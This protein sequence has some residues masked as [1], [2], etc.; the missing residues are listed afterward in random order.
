MIRLWRRG[1]P[2]VTISVPAVERCQQRR[3]VPCHCNAQPEHGTATMLSADFVGE[4][5]H[6]VLLCPKL[7]ANEGSRCRLMFCDNWSGRMLWYAT[8][9]EEK[10]LRAKLPSCHPS[11]CHSWTHRSPVESLSVASRT[12]TPL[13]PEEEHYKGKSVAHSSQTRPTLHAR[14]TKFW[15]PGACHCLMTRLNCSLKLHVLHILD[16]Q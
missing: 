15:G 16:F 8:R 4:F 11:Q 6:T 13:L 3:A 1:L 2:Q 9:A 14:L 7:T 10:Q 12:Q 5:L